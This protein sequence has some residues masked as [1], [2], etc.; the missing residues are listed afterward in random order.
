MELM[1]M[2]SMRVPTNTISRTIFGCLSSEVYAWSR[3]FREVAG[4]KEDHDPIQLGGYNKVVEGDGMFVLATRKGGV[5]RWHSKEHIYVVV[6]RGT[7]KIRRKVV[8]DKSATV[9]SVFDHHIVDGSIFMCDP[10]KENQHF[11]TLSSVAEVYE[12]PG[13]IHVD[14][15]NRFKNTQT[16]EG[17]HAEP[18]MRLRLGRGLRRHN[19]QAVMD[20]ED[21]VRNRTDG[22]PQDIFKHLGSAAFLYISIKH[23][24]VPR[25]S[26][27]SKALRPDHIEP[28]QNLTRTLIKKLC[29]DSVYRR[30]KIF[31][32]ASS[33]LISTCVTS[34]TNSIVGE[35]R[36]ALIY[37]QSIYWGSTAMESPFSLDTIRVFCTCKYYNK[38][39]ITHGL[40]CKHI[41]GQ[42]RRVLHLS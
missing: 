12:I 38:E 30:A 10:G 21:F 37:E 40:C 5:G 25:T 6:E 7:R 36:A 31:D 3:F 24:D 19:L 26:L 33:F 35:Y 27:I 22:T 8:K 39:T 32:V 1:W 41:I 42:L 17:S 11:K 4:Y 2:I 13:P 18:K 15:N 34:S 14:L 23:D 9:L 28:I 29:T 16:V 20:F